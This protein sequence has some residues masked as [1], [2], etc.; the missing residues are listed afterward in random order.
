[1]R[2][3]CAPAVARRGTSREAPTYWRDARQC[4]S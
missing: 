3:D 2:R 4:R 1:V